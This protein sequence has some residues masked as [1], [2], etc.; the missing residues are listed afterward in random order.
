[1]GGSVASATPG[2]GGT[3]STTQV[4]P[5]IE[6]RV[7]CDFTAV[8]SGASVAT[9]VAVTTTADGQVNV[10]SGMSTTNADP[11]TGNNVATA[12]TTVMPAPSSSSSSGGGSGG[13]GG[14][15]LDWLLAGL[16]G[17]LLARRGVSG[18]VRAV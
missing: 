6:T 1:M 8:A 3:C 18:R 7:D 11:V 13:G 2:S 16:L 14:G 5:Q 9:T 4:Q 10:G 15:G 17:A 12:T